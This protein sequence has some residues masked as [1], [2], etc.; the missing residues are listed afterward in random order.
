MLFVVKED[1][2][3]MLLFSISSKQHF[4]TLN[5]WD[6]FLRTHRQ[7][8]ISSDNETIGPFSSYHRYHMVNWFSELHTLTQLPFI[9]IC[10]PLIFYL[11]VKYFN[12]KLNIFV[13][14]TF[15]FFFFI[16]QIAKREKFVLFIFPSFFSQNQ[17]TKIFFDIAKITFFKNLCDI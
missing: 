10:V 15:S 13:K 7:T 12:Y 6:F 11:N 16:F 17:K 5:F 8:Q 2:N 9:I 14:L 1:K 3:K 4:P